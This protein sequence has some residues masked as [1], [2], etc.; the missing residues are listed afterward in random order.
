MSS[1]G[2]R[3]KAR[4]PRFRPEDAMVVREGGKVTGYEF[5]GAGPGG[6]ERTVFVSADGKTV[7]DEDD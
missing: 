3:L 6:K 2:T 7:E 5:E 1:P 4:M